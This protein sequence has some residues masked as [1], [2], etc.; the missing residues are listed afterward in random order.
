[1][2][3]RF[4]SALVFFNADHFKS[5]VKAMVRQAQIDVRCVLL[6]AETM[7]FVDTTGAA[8]LDEVCKALAERGIL[9]AIAGA[10]APVR[11]MLDQTGVSQQI[12]AGCVFPTLQSAVQAL[13]TPER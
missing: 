2:I 10:R 1:M 7:P 9:F 11:V 3:Y 13:S 8:S 4:D 6:D 12:G 5:Q